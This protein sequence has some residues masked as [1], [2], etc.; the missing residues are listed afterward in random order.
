MRLLSLP[1][2]IHLAIHFI[3]HFWSIHFAYLEPERC[4]YL[5]PQSVIRKSSSSSLRIYICIYD[6]GCDRTHT[7]IIPHFGCG[8]SCMTSFTQPHGLYM[9]M[10]MNPSRRRIQRYRGWTHRNGQLSGTYTLLPLYI[11]IYRHNPFVARMIERRHPYQHPHITYVLQLIL[12]TLVVVFFTFSYQFM[13]NEL[14][15]GRQCAYMH[16]AVGGYLYTYTLPDLNQTAAHTSIYRKNSRNTT[17]TKWGLLWS[18][19][20]PRVYYWLSSRFQLLLNRTKRARLIYA[21]WSAADVRE[22]T[23]I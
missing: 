10:T 2:I 16:F 7:R 13:N 19:R 6:V 3:H 8:D 5:S 23:C 9:H 18:P 12:C 20:A 22:L 17:H 14:W 21:R 4:V 11:Y 1:Y 15:R